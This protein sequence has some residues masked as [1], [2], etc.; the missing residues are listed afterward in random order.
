MA[1][2]VYKRHK[3][4]DV[5]RT[6]YCP[7][8][9]TVKSFDDFTKNNSSYCKLSSSCRA[10]MAAYKI[11]HREKNRERLLKKSNEHYYANR[12]ELLEKRYFDKYGI[13]TERRD[14]ILAEQGGVCWI[15]GEIPNTRWGKKL[16]T[17]H[18]H[19]T[20]VVRGMLCHH[21]NIAIGSM[22][23][24]PELLERAALYLKVNGGGYVSSQ[25]DNAA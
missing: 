9:D 25:K 2:R 8:C 4:D 15:C 24:R 22:R 6:K 14:K 13:T 20:G 7:Q 5:A 23:D 11:R 16:M 21:C 3:T 1:Q 19:E 17:D 18:C 12:D 10:C